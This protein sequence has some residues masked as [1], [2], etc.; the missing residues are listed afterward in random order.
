MGDGSADFSRFEDWSLQHGGAHLNNT[1]SLTQGFSPRY[2]YE[3]D[4]GA[5]DT[6]GNPALR[7]QPYTKNDSH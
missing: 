3:W 4:K 2:R 1:H 7:P 6:Q 5:P